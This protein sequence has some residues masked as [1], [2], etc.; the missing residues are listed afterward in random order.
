MTEFEPAEHVL[1]RL[2]P[3]ESYAENP[4]AFWEWFHSQHPD[5]SR[6]EMVRALEESGGSH[7]A[8]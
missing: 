6:E 7:D 8:K 2:I 1:F 3:H 4:D 5:V